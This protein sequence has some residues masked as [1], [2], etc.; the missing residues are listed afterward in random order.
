MG[1]NRR[2]R[3]LIARGSVR[4]APLR[5][6]LLV[7]PRDTW[8]PFDGGIS[9]EAGGTAPD[10]SQRFR[11]VHSVAYQVGCLPCT[12]LQGLRWT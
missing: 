2:M 6:G 1:A 8:P 9:M 12:P 4:R 11:Y 5:R 10:G 7:A 3:R